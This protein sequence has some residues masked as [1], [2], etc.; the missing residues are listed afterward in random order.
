MGSLSWSAARRLGA[1]RTTRVGKLRR[2]SGKSPLPQATEWCCQCRASSG[3]FARCLSP[4]EAAGVAVA[5]ASLP[6]HRLP[7]FI[8][9]AFSEG[10]LCIL[11]REDNSQAEVVS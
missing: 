6:A 7:L 5:G 10:G 1:Q 11:G 2:S 9:D 4:K 8:P 3:P